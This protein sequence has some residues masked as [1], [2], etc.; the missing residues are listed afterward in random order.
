VDERLRA[1]WATVIAARLRRARHPVIASHV[2]P[3]GDAWSSALGLATALRRLDIATVVLAHEPVAPHLAF[4]EGS[5]TVVLLDQDI[6]ALDP[7]ALP[8]VERGCLTLMVPPSF[9]EPTSLS[10]TTTRIR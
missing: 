7:I 4:L 5:D 8:I 9:P 6:S 2:R 10:S 3:D 1:A